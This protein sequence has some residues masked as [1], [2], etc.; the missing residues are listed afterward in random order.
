VQLAQ[1][2][3]E[4]ST[5]VTALNAADLTDT[6]SGK[7]LFTL[8]AP[9]NAAF[10]KLPE[11]TLNFLL[12]DEGKDELTS[13]LLYHVTHGRVLSTQL[14]EGEEIPTLQGADVTVTEVSPHV[15]INDA[16]VVYANVMATNG[17]LHMIDTVLMP[18]RDSSDSAPPR[19]TAAFAAATALAFYVL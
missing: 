3:P 16:K 18:P 1:G 2:T 19:A 10:A 17:V 7:A 12:S 13:I 9:S 8:F 14:I 11:E 5:L 4:L 15:I 6:L